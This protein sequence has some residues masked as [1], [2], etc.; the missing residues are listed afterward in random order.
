[1]PTVAC[2]TYLRRSCT[3]SGR[4]T[5]SSR[6]SFFVHRPSPRCCYSFIAQGSTGAR[7]LAN[8]AA[9][10]LDARLFELRRGTA[11]RVLS[12]AEASAKVSRL[13]FQV[14]CWHINKRRW[15][16]SEHSESIKTSNRGRFA[17]TQP[18]GRK[19][20]RLCDY[21]SGIP[22]ARASPQSISWVCMRM[23][24]WCSMPDMPL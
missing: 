22:S 12:R 18:L 6:C 1:M 24:R 3:K 7:E 5:T 23:T 13:A 20:D 11:G 10:L 21:Y 4:A 16:H 19:V 2:T 8:L 17:L 15:Q 14:G 9:S